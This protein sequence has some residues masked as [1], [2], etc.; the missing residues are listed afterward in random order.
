MIYQESENVELKQIIT[1]DIK[2]EIIAFANTKGGDLF[3]GV[4]DNGEVIG[5]FDPDSAILQISNMVRDNIKP[6]ITMFIN[7]EI[8]NVN[9]VYIIRISIQKGAQRPYYLQ[10]KGLRPEGV[11]V[12]QGTTSVPA[13]L[14]MIGQMIKESDGDHFEAMRSLR[15]DLSLHSLYKEFE[16]RNIPLAE[17][18]M[19]T[20]GIQNEDGLYTNLGLLLS[21]QCPFTTKV[22]VFQ[23]KTQEIFNDR[24]EF[25]GSILKQLNDIYAYIDKYNKISSSYDQLLR[26]DQRDYPEI[27][28]REALLNT[29]IHREYAMR[30]STLISIYEDRIEFLSVGGLAPTLSVSDIMLGVSLCRNEQL[31]NIFYRLQLIEAY[32]TGIRKIFTA[33]KDFPHTPLIE[34]SEHAFKI[35]LYN[36]NE[37]HEEKEEVSAYDGNQEEQIKIIK[38]IKECGHITRKQTQ[39]LCHMTQTTAGR[40]LRRMVEQELLIQAGRGSQTKYYKK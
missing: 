29:Y 34:V 22:A 36:R 7:Y 14:T 39:E 16:K 26:I 35:T 37:S 2:K 27:A 40:L 25:Q 15:Q 33:Y 17:G 1:D 20:L 4:A 3:V 8:L 31:A 5:V 18:Q 19:R 11:Y 12:R 30:A 28:I 6:D 10:K 32:G 21:D 38:F 24:Q 23:G 13:S 9:N